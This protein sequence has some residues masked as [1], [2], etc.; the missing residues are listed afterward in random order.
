MLCRAGASCASGSRGLPAEVP[1]PCQNHT[2]LLEA[3]RSGAR[4]VALA[5]AC[6][7][8]STRS[9]FFCTPQ[10]QRLT[11]ITLTPRRL[12]TRSRAAP[13][14]QRAGCEGACT[15]L[16][17]PSWPGPAH[18]VQL[19]TDACQTTERRA[20][21]ARVQVSAGPGHGHCHSRAL[22]PAG[23]RRRA[24]QLCGM[25]FGVCKTLFRRHV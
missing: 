7:I 12:H 4:R 19:P 1:R 20:L 24:T 10:V 5:V 3:P 23:V 11:K 25:C 16:C 18:C 2:R 17:K 13:Y 15:R 9:P 6:H 22:Y 8:A 21:D 14:R